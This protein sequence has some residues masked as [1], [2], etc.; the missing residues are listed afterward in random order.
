M[1]RLRLRDMIAHRIAL[2]P[3]EAATL[4]LAVA[5]EWDRRREVYAATI[6]PDARAIVLH[7]NG[8]ITFLTVTCAQPIDESVALSRLFS[9]LLGMD[10]G[11]LAWALR[12]A[13]ASVSTR[14]VVPFPRV[15]Q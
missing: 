8:E 9:R 13:E 10:D 14:T 12:S 5:R 6:L 7:R 11:R 15:V 4:T 2:S 3:R 1:N